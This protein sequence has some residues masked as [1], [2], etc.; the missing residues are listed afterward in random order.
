V[1]VE[2]YLIVMHFSSMQ[3]E[4]PYWVGISRNEIDKDRGNWLWRANVLECFSDSIGEL[5]QILYVA[6]KKSNENGDVLYYDPIRCIGVG[7]IHS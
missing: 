6:N 1:R 7:L 2:K 5:A 3:S 4:Y